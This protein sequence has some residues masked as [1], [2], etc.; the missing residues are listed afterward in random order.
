MCFTVDGQ[1]MRVGTGRRRASTAPPWQAPR[2][3]CGCDSTRLCEPAFQTGCKT[4]R[5]DNAIDQYLPRRCDPCRATFSAKPRTAD[6]EEK[7]NWLAGLNEV[8]LGSDAFFPFR[9]SI[10]RAVMS[11]VKYVL[12]PG[13][14]DRDGSCGRPGLRMIWNGDG[15]FRGEVIH[16]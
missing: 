13:R 2:Q 12:Q 9:D 16:H 6:P 3:T 7:R 11:G 14:S 1:V 10:D 15:I 5:R 8:V 4:P